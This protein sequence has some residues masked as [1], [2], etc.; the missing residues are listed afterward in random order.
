MNVLVLEMHLQVKKKEEICCRNAEHET[1][2]LMWIMN[3]D[4]VSYSSLLG[5]LS[6]VEGLH[7]HTHPRRVHGGGLA[8]GMI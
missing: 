4:G 6:G 5:S 2:R 8:H 1:P 3:M 7:S